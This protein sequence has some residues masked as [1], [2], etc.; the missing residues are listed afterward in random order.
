MPTSRSTSCKRSC[1]MHARSRW[2]RAGSAR[3]CA[4]AAA[5]S[6]P[7]LIAPTSRRPPQSWS[8]AGLTRATAPVVSQYQ[9]QP[10]YGGTP[11]DQTLVDRIRDLAAR[12]LSVTLNPFVLMDIAAGNALRQPARRIGQP[13]GLPLART[14]H[15]RSGPCPIRHGRQD[16]CCGDPARE[17]HRL[18]AAFA[19]LALRRY[20]RLFR[21]GRVV[22]SPLH[23]ASRLARE[24]CRR[25]LG[26]SDRKRIAGADDN[27][28][29]RIGVSVRRSLAATRN[30]LTVDTRRRREDPLFGRLVGIL[31]LSAG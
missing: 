28:I 7:R 4:A 8:V 3:T 11:S 5:T 29:D 15:L 31:R 10:A 6:S 18:R 2:S 1:R 30:R 20:D 9:G 24:S 12:G 25:R 23:P 16:G 13:T 17:L 19:L 26:I 27:P 14:H 22:L 21:P